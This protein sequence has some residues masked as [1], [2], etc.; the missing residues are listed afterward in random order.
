MLRRGRLLT[1]REIGMLAAV[2]LAEVA[3]WRRPRVAVLSTGDEIVAPGE[4]IQPGQV[5][6][7]NAAILAA[8]VAEAGG[9]AVAHGIVRD[10]LDAL[11][12]ALDRALADADVVLL[13]GGTSKGAGDLAYQ[14][15][16][17]LRRRPRHRRA[18]RRAE[19]GQAAV[20]RGLRRQAAGDPARLPDLGDL[21]LP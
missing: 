14:A 5:F 18:R 19:A 1:A 2:G 8:S 7:S 3:V 15:L 11:G 21:H 4:P 10:D 17:R 6:D 9:E 20:P 16:A 13:S 12:V